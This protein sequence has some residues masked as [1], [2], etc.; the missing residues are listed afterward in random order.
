VCRHLHELVFGHV[1]A[2]AVGLLTLDP[3]LLS[4]H[5]DGLEELIVLVFAVSFFDGGYRV[6][7]LFAFASDQPLHADLDPVPSLIAIHD[8]VA[9]DDCCDVPQPDFLGGL[10]QRLHVPGGRLGIRVTA[11]TKE[12][13]VSLGDSHVFGDLEQLYQVV[14]VRVDP[15][16]GDQPAEVKSAISVNCSL[17]RFL[18]RLNILELLVLDGLGNADGILPDHSPGANVEM[19]DFAVAHE[20]LG[21]TDGQ[22]RGFEFGEALGGLG[23]LLCE[24]IHGWRVCGENSIAIFA[25]LVGSYAPAVNDDKYR[26][27]V[28]LCHGESVWIEDE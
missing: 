13:N 16:V 19:T 10:Q 5:D 28:D 9:S 12:V 8:V 3:S 17:E 18:D 25:R 15:A 23:A 27:L 20:A 2:Q 7:T 11:V 14:H 24:V 6:A 26:L 4:T 22:G 21:K 1:G